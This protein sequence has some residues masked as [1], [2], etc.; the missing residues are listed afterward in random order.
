MKDNTRKRRRNTRKWGWTVL[1]CALVVSVSMLTWGIVLL[2]RENAERE[3]EFTQPPQAQTEPVIHAQPVPETVTQPTTA[4][5]TEPTT[6]PP[7]TTPPQMLSNMEELYGENPDIVGW[8]KID[9]TRIDYP[10]MHTPSDPEKYLHLNFD[11]KFSFGGLP[12][13]DASCSVDP[14]S[15]N[16]LIYGHNMQNGTMFR[17]L[18]RYDAKTFWQDHSTIHFSTLYEEREYEI[19]A[20]FYD[21]VYYPEEDHFKFYQFIDAADK[22]EFDTAITYFKLKS[23][24]DT[25]VSA[26]Y[27]DSLITLVTC[28]YH[29]DNGRFVVVAREVKD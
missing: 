23:L 20:A 19:I 21:R 6:L 7:E 15:D 27:G 4:P 8:I 18:M 25:G 11:E 24:Y 29:V 16:L 13:I 14:E 17:D 9:N 5:A 10:V 1:L 26:E 3:L 28:A 22:E 2:I 12:F